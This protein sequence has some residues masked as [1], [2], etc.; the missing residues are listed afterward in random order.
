MRNLELVTAN[1]Q[2]RIYLAASIAAILAVALGAFGAHALSDLLIANDRIR[3]FETANQYHFYHSFGL[4][5][6]GAL[7]NQGFSPSLLKAAAILM[8]VGIL[9]FSGSLYIL[10]ISDKS[11]LGAIAPLGGGAF[12][13]SWWLTFKA[14]LSKSN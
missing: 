12:L 13:V 11:W 9:L 2:R 4:F 10:S 1:F 6:L 5:V 14:V 3:T 7:L 8:C